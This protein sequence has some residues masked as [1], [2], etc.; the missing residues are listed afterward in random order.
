MKAGRE[1]DD[2]IEEKVFGRDRLSARE[3]GDGTIQW[4]FGYPVGHD[5]ARQFSTE[6]R[7]TT[8]LL[9]ELKTKSCVAIDV[10]PTHTYVH[11]EIMAAGRWITV[12]ISAAT[13]P[14]ALCLFALN[15]V[16]NKELTAK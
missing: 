16:E 12:R 4:H 10:F 15:L 2:L 3:M 7:W 11:T 1:L 13:T 9:D 6:E 14:L 5:I 8:T